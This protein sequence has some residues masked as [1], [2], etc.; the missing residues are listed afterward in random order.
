M[1]SLLRELQEPGKIPPRIRLLCNGWNI[2]PLREALERHPH[3][4][5]A[6]TA[7]TASPESPHHGTS[8]IWARYA[9]AG[10]KDEPHWSVWYSAA[11]CIPVR[12]YASEIMCAVGGT[13][14]GG[15][16]ITKVPAG[17]AIKPHIDNSWHAGFYDKFALQ[18]AAAPGQRFCYEDACLESEVGD[19]YWFRNDVLHWVENPTL[20]DRITLIVCTRMEL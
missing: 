7:R 18:I 10:V 2:D 12:E 13:C 5:D 1:N 8:D 9:P 20:H 3:L 11:D 15:V 16:L 19:L 4:W 14:L 17:G 6:E